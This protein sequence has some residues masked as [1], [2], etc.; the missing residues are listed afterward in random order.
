MPPPR[1]SILIACLALLGAS[2]PAAFAAEAS[3]ETVKLD[4]K[5]VF[6]P[7]LQLTQKKP[8]LVT[9]YLFV[10]AWSAGTGK[11][12]NSLCA[13]DTKNNAIRL[14]SPGK[15]LDGSRTRVVT[16]NG[17]DSFLDT[18]T[19]EGRRQVTQI[20]FKLTTSARRLPVIIEITN[21]SS[22]ALYLN[23]KFAGSVSA[24]NAKT[25]G[26]RCYFPVTL[27]AGDT[28]VNF[29]ISSQGKP[30][31][32]LAVCLD[33]SR[34]LAA[35]LQPRGGLLKKLLHLPAEHADIPALA[36]NPQLVNFSPSVEIRNISTNEIVFQKESVRQGMLNVEAGVPTAFSP[37]V[38]EAIY[39]AG[40]DSAS[41]SFIVG[42][43][44]DLFAKLQEQLSH[45][46]PD[47]ESKLDI[48]AQLRRAQIL[49]SRE[50]YNVFD[51]QFQEKLAYTFGA[52]ETCERLLKEGATNIA[53]NQRG[54]HI[55]AVLD[56]SGDSLN[57]YKLFIPSNYDPA[58]PL[59]LLVIVSTRVAKPRPFI[60]GPVMANFREWLSWCKLADQ[61]GVALLWPGY[62]GNSDGQT[63][64][65]VYINTVIQ[66]VEKSVN[67]ARDKVGLYA[68]CGA[69][70]NAGR[71]VSEY[72]NRFSCIIYDRAVFNLSL[73]DSEQHSA[74]LE[75]WL[76]AANPVPH[77]IENR[78]LKI[79]VMHDDTK[80]A[81]H[82]PMELSTQFLE[83]A[84]KA[85]NDVISK[86][87]HQPM[88]DTIRLDM[89]FSWLAT[90][91]NENPNDTRTH[92]LA[93]TGYTGPIMEIFAT[94]LL[95]VEG[96]RTVG[97]DL[98]AIHEVAE[99]LGRNY[100][101]FFHGA[102]CIIMKDTEV[103]QDDINNHSLILLGNP[104]SN[105]VWE[106]LQSHLPVKVTTSEVMLNNDS[107]AVSRPFQAIVRHPTANDKYILM[108]G[109]GD[110]KYLRQVTTSNLFTAWYDCLVFSPRK[111][112]SKLSVP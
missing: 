25:S 43:P 94:P 91:R 59:P 96:T 102:Q 42:N 72:P 41:E 45:Y 77:V 18:I 35:A 56:A 75:E 85:R 13:I 15:L 52:L 95:V 97:R 69:G 73:S 7:E 99:A 103:T 33:H 67:V 104:Q 27:E 92:Y 3:V 31:I 82:G 54:M 84:G 9:S 23:G 68:T 20:A 83:Q 39:R 76:K 93:K 71:L 32:Q 46:N 21:D 17:V 98:L 109:A 58:V 89:I 1:A 6:L 26:G 100:A 34:D 53:K 48:E 28:I 60:E 110:L 37:G 24:N 107:L 79:F 50:N 108:I 64:E 101:K 11:N 38:Y 65:S 87:S 57:A 63:L 78:N 44:H 30:R 51:R 10:G 5:R 14:E 40:G 16:Q 111:I 70:Y 74:P 55:R 80:P 86:L 4:G 62:R 8:Y 88:L 12:K 90:C 36:W 81:G 47:A 22:S 106:K 2:C 19:W 49:L 66:S 112:I 105:S 29:K 61:H